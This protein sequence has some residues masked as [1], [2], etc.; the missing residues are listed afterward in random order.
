[1]SFSARVTATH[2]RCWSASAPR[3][4]SVMA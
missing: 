2:C 4:S 3:P 1:M